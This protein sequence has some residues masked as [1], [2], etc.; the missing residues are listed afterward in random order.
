MPDQSS[1]TAGDLRLPLHH[2]HPHPPPTRAEML[3]IFFRT[4][5]FTGFVSVCRSLIK[6]WTGVQ[7]CGSLCTD[8][9]EALNHKTSGR[10]GRDFEGDVAGV[11]QS[12]QVHAAQADTR[13]R[14][15]EATLDNI[16][17]CQTAQRKSRNLLEGARQASQ[18]EIKA[19]R[20][21]A[22]NTDT[23]LTTPILL[24]G[25]AM[26]RSNLSQHAS[27]IRDRLQ[28]YR[29]DDSRSR[30]LKVASLP[31]QQNRPATSA[32][33]GLPWRSRVHLFAEGR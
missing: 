29:L 4:F 33:C 30:Q 24:G 20:A 19:G 10:S 16:R 8:E 1:P 27:A 26:A 22:S 3:A 11:D 2:R 12:M 14:G 23:P 13:R 5:S 15:G 31:T 32:K 18:E 9:S 25:F 7:D 21:G 17:P 28:S 6:D